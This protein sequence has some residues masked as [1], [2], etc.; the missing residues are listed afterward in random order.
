MIQ[1][2]SGRA[3]DRSPRSAGSP[4][5][6]ASLALAR[7]MACRKGP[8]SL[9]A[10]RSHRT[11]ATA[12][13]GRSA[14][15][16]RARRRTSSPVSRMNQGQGWAEASSLLPAPP[17]DG[18]LGSV[19]SLGRCLRR[20]IELAPLV[21][22]DLSAITK[23]PHRPSV[24]A[25]AARPLAA[26]AAAGTAAGQLAQTRAQSSRSGGGHRGGHRKS[27]RMAVGPVHRLVP[28]RVHC[29]PAANDG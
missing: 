16:A 4:R 23:S 18:G 22:A 9:N 20:S 24:L 11:Q 14:S 19:P 28:G 29:R 12:L 5:W 13:A 25:I 6:P 10:G 3:R 27:A 26:S 1:F 15:C 21:R 17:V 7:S 8:S 2:L